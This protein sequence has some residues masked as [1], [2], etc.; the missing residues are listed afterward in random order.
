MRLKW[1][2]VY[3]KILFDGK[4]N[5]ITAISANI[6]DK[7]NVT[8]RKLDN[9]TDKECDRRDFL[10]KSKNWAKAVKNIAKLS[11][12]AWLFSKVLGCSSSRIYT[13][14]EKQIMETYKKRAKTK[15]SGHEF[16]DLEFKYGTSHE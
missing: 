11:V 7:C 4:C 1:I 9:L 5:E 8:L 10:I 3:R 13:K 15:T 16:V 2:W 14:D 12:S 6:Y